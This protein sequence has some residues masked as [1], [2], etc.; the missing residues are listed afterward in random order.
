MTQ[1]TPSAVGRPINRLDG[2]A[3][4]TG[5]ATYAADAPLKNIAFAEIIQSTIASGKITGIDTARA[6]AIPGVLAVLTPQ[7]MP[8]LHKT[9]AGMIAEARPPLSDMNVHYAGQHIAVVVAD[10][11]ECAAHAATLVNVSY[12]RA[13]PVISIDDPNAK[14]EKPAEN[15]G[16]EMQ[17]RRGNVDKILADTKDLFVL[18]AAYET[19]V[20]THNPMEMS[21]TT[22]LWDAPDRLT[23]WDSTQHVIGRRDSLADIF[24]LEPTNVRVLTYFVG[25]GFGCKGA[26]W[27]HAV[28]AA[29][30]AKVTGR[31][32]KLMLKRSQMFTSCGHRPPTRQHMTLAASRDGKLLAIRHDT[33]MHGSTVGDYVEPCGTASSYVMYDTPNLEIIHTVK[34][35]NVATPTFMRAP[36]ETPGIYALECAMDELAYELKI[37]PVKLRLINYAEKH[38]STGKVWS[39]KNLKEIYQLGSDK[40]GWSNRNPEPSSMKSPEGRTIGWGMATASYPARK[41]PSSARIRLIKDGDRG[42]RAVGASAT[43]DIGTGTYTIAAQMTADQVGLPIE[44][45]KFD[46]GDSYLPPAGVS[47]GSSTAAGMATAISE[48]GAALR[49]A[50]LDLANRSGDTTLANLSSAQVTLQNG[51]LIASDIPSRAI[52]IAALMAKNNKPYIEGISPTRNN[53]DTP[54]P[55][56]DFAYQSFGAHFVEVTVGQLAPTVRVNRVVSVMDVGRVVNP[57]TARS[58]VMGGIVMGVGMALVEETIY[59][60]NT[61]RPINDNL[62]DYVVP[63]NPDIGS[64]EIHF[65]DKPDLHFNPVGC[66]GVGEIGITGLAA[67]IANAVH[68]ATGK[69]VRDLP[70][71][72]EKL[73]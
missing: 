62:A 38:P 21:A 13:K 45:V 22:A 51:R 12:E 19:P 41:F 73:T 60:Q 28:L 53:G 66:R 29:A 20:E 63:V 10:S 18:R 31:P 61:A 37:D 2:R 27:P 44:Q 8:K 1:T 40:F 11:P 46:L 5:R 26:A 7:N 15:M 48:A 65:I 25:G 71:T 30:A 70:I 23:V 35:V 57:K 49:S 42:L 3:K 59:D 4:V 50:I 52:D 56:N 6:L 72:C 17:V 14:E 68:H 67:A 55:L 69:R 24:G 34:K 43:Q 39:T 54:V 32:V 47:G 9:K 36:G 33:T 58:Q 64:I 16:E